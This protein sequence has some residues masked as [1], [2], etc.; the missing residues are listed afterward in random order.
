L[1]A[2]AGYSADNHLHKQKVNEIA[3]RAFLTNDSNVGISNTSPADYLAMVEEKYP[4]AL[5]K[6]FIPLN[7][8]LWQLDHYEAFLQQRRELIARAYNAQMQYLLADLP[9][10]QK[11]PLAG[12]IAN[13]E[14]AVLE[15]KSTLR[16]DVR[17]QQVNKDLQ[18]VIAK[19]IAGFL[20][21]EGG[22]L[23]IG[24]ADDGSI[25][26]IEQD[27]DS[28]QRNDRDGFEQGLVQVLENFIGGEYSPYYRWSFE[29]STGKLVCIV[30]VDPSPKP[31]F[32]TDKQNPEFY[33]RMGNTTRP[34]DAQETHEYIGLHWES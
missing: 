2:E 21:S 29:E 20:N 23:L 33:I 24:V 11:Q 27:I 19:T 34:L 9:A 30:M 25:Y 13:G 32:L 14:S 28:L 16:W 26:G 12:L 8:V 31:V 18:K 6:Q 3:N 10:A 5:Q 15:F 22:T 7:P 4:G 1:Y 17:A